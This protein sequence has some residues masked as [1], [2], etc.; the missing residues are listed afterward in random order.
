[1]NSSRDWGDDLDQPLPPDRDMLRRLVRGAVAFV[2]V[3]A[4]VAAGWTGWRMWASGE[5]L[6]A[7]ARN[8]V[9]EALDRRPAERAVLLNEAERLMRD[10][11]HRGGRQEDAAR[12]L[13]CSALALNSFRNAD[14][15]VAWELEIE[16]LLDEIQPRA[17][18]TEDLLTAVDVFIRTGQ[19]AQADWLMGTALE[20]T[21]NTGD[22]H[23]VLRLAAD[24]RYDLGREQA[25]LEHCEEMIK[26]DPADPEP[27][28]LMA[29]VYEDGGY[30]ERFIQALDK[31]LELDSGDVSEERLKL[32]ES[33]VALGNRSR[34]REQ[35]SLL[36]AQAP[37][38]LARHPL[39]QAK[40]LL[41]EGETAQAQPIIQCVLE[42]HPEDAEAVVLS[43]KLHL[44]QQEFAAAVELLERLLQREP[45]H[46]EAHFLIGQAYARQGEKERA[47]WH[48][49]RHR[50]ILDTRVL[51]H[52]LERTAGKNPGDVQTRLEIVKLYERLGL[53]DLADFWQRA[54]DSAGYGVRTAP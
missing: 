52:R 38:R 3:S 13:L 32:V 28:R 51:L 5:P 22:Y 25:V 19:L 21:R 11:M 30:T 34:A 12:L 48:L 26:I 42:A 49:E 31:V 17:C 4:L 7:E 20:R 6:I 53:K 47:Q 8:L 18:S 24:L 10:Y 54:A 27:W 44:S 35:Y 36:A 16:D 50:Q 14:A 46:P 43:S 39:V 37:Q 2:L 9:Q 29:L 15:P 33:L 41:I 45:M 40:L 1:M 23:R